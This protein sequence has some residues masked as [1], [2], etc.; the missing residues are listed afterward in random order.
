M[1]DNKQLS[2]YF[3]IIA[4]GCM[5]VITASYLVFLYSS[6]EQFQNDRAKRDDKI[7]ELLARFPKKVEPEA[8]ASE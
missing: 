2:R 1:P 5:V 4:I 7:D 3:A 6:W 8:K